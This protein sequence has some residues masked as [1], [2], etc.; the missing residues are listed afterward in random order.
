MAHWTFTKPLLAT[1]KVFFTLEVGN[2]LASWLR[3][4]QWCWVLASTSNYQ[5][6]YM[7]TGLSLSIH[8]VEEAWP[9]F[10]MLEHLTL[11][12]KVTRYHKR[13]SHGH[14][15]RIL[16]EGDPRGSNSTSLLARPGQCFGW[17]TQEGHRSVGTSF[18]PYPSFLQDLQHS[19]TWTL[20][21]M[22]AE[23]NLTAQLPIFNS[24]TL[25][26]LGFR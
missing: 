25:A 12:N 26:A 2:T 10:D 22:S 23:C 5:A 13:A 3:A 16:R 8:A 24:L 14:L 15:R 11:N 9:S 7:P 19:A 20:V 1:G 17:H 6:R 18:S 4:G 21:A